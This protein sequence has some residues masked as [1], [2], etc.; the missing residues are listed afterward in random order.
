MN[1]E[2]ILDYIQSAPPPV[3]RRNIARHFKVRGD[4]SRIALKKALKAMVNDGQIIKANGGYMIPDSLP[5]VVVVT[6][7]DIT[8]D[9][10]ILARPQDWDEG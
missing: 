1:T 4:T 10:D 2:E 6:V 5:G 3:P 8:D 7:T 9:G